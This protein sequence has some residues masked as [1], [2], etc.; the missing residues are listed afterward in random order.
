MNFSNFELFEFSN[1]SN[2]NFPKKSSPL[3]S[4]GNTKW[5][6]RVKNELLKMNG[7]R[8]SATTKTP[9]NKFHKNAHELNKP[10]WNLLLAK[11]CWI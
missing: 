2:L 5:K 11:N 4:C 9:L 6:L 8:E 10:H 3:P 7:L 1:F